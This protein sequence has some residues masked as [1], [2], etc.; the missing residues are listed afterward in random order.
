MVVELVASVCTFPG[1]TVGTAGT[2]GRRLVV[3]LPGPL[4]WQ[5]DPGHPGWCPRTFPSRA[6]ALQPVPGPRAQPLHRVLSPGS[7]TP[8]RHKARRALAPLGP[9]PSPCPSLPTSLQR[10]LGHLHA[11]HPQAGAV[12]RR[13]LDLVVGP[14]DEVLQEQVV[15]VGVGDV[16][17]L[18]AHGQPG[19]AVPG[20]EGPSEPPAPPRAPRGRWGQGARTPLL[21]PTG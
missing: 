20:H 1:G 12:V 4:P 13:H 14:D 2:K 15:D 16:L 7:L 10:P 5:R 18:V 6:M 11:V 3:A 8:P 17:E 21:A 9:P 19:Q